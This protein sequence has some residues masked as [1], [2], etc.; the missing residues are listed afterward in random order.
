MLLMISIIS[1]TSIVSCTVAVVI[2][3]AGEREGKRK[4]GEESGGGKGGWSEMA[5]ISC[6]HLLGVPC[7]CVLLLLSSAAA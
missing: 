6:C 5:A 1:S 7:V 4:G 3:L 2:T